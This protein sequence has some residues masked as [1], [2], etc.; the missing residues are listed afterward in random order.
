MIP[1][2]AWDSGQFTGM[3]T[4]TG[5][6]KDHL[7]YHAIIALF[8]LSDNRAGVDRLFIHLFFKYS[9]NVEK[10]NVSLLL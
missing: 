10:R 9:T 2:C 7:Q 1:R 8:S 5:H 3:L 6:L 4:A